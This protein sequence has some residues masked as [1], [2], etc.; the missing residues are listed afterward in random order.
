MLT[1]CI[2]NVLEAHLTF[3]T[4]E[5]KTTLSCTLEERL[6]FVALINHLFPLKLITRVSWVNSHKALRILDIGAKTLELNDAIF[7]IDL[8]HV[9]LFTLAI[10]RWR[11]LKVDYWSLSNTVAF[12]DQRL[13][14]RVQVENVSRENSR[15]VSFY[16]KWVK[17]DNEVVVTAG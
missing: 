12:N 7:S 6:L 1:N 15:H 3:L 4:R 16:L 10:S 2:G 9:F 17:F 13:L 14:L 8:S 11:K 5:D